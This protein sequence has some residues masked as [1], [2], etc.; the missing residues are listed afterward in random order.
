MVAEAPFEQ[1]N[2]MNPHVIWDA[3]RNVWRMWY[4]AGEMY[5]PNVNCY[6][7]S[8]DG[9]KWT[10]SPLN[11]VLAKGTRQWEQNR[12][13]GCEVHPLPDGT[14]V[15]FYIGY[16]DIHTAAIGAAEPVMYFSFDK[17]ANA[18]IGGIAGVPSAKSTDKTPD[19]RIRF[20][21]KGLS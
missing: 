16:K 10:K 5:E 15:M 17:N 4:S 19:K 7:E 3:K 14:F 12:V 11:P 8:K 20:Y 18:D 1:K 2:V 6:A 13:G 9:I 21:S